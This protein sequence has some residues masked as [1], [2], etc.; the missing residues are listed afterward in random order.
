[1]EPERII[2]EY[3]TREKEG[4]DSAYGILRRVNQINA[5][6]FERALFS[7]FRQ[8]GYEDFSD[9]IFLDIGCGTGGLLLRWIQWGASP[10]NCRGIDLVPHRLEQARQRL[11]AAVHLL[12]D[13]ASRLPFPDTMFDVTSQLTVLSSILDDDMQHAVAR[14]ML[15]VTKP[16]GIII[17]YDF[18]LNPTN[19]AT[20][21]VGVRRLRELFPNCELYT[22]RITLAPP[23]A[24]RLAPWA[25][26]LC[27]LLESLKLLNSHY[28]VMIKPAR[29]S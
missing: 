20:R 25:P 17:S 1:M 27:R 22:Q 15:R 18:W 9:K 13:D 3:V 14:E 4:R 19:P 10:E 12:A 24:R 7:V 26:W 5:H 29:K 16:D 23:I 11:P 2:A 21:G 8:A 28:L 6:S